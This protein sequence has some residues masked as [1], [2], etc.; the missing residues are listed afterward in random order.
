MSK[1]EERESSDSS[2]RVQFGSASK[3]GSQQ[4]AG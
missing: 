4:S 1:L 2:A 3:S